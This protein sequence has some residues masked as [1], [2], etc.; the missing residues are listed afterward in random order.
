MTYITIHCIGKR[1]LE[2]ENLMKMAVIYRPAEPPMQKP[3]CKNIIREI[4]EC[5]SH[6]K[7]F[8]II[9]TPQPHHRST[10]HQPTT[11]KGS[12]PQSPCEACAPCTNTPPSALA[13]PPHSTCP[14]PSPG[15]SQSQPRSPRPDSRWKS[16]PRSSEASM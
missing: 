1:K 14:A 8:S 5:K 7:R 4:S 3:I 2:V 10:F 12:K 15:A 16:G 9:L 11:V 13:S 6:I